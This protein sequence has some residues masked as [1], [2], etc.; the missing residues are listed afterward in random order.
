MKLFVNNKRSLAILIA[1]SF[2]ILT[3]GTA[4]FSIAK[5]AGW[6]TF[7]KDKPS[8]GTSSASSTIGSS[9]TVVT[10]VQREFDY[11]S[12]LVTVTLTP[13]ADYSLNQDASLFMQE[14]GKISQELLTI[15][16]NAVI[17]NTMSGD[18]PIF[19]EGYTAYLGYDPMSILISELRGNNFRIY[20]TYDLS[21]SYSITSDSVRNN[22]ANLLEFCSK[23]KPDGILLDG[24]YNVQNKD[25]PQ[26]YQKSGYSIPQQEWLYRMSAGNLSYI[27]SQLKKE[28]PSVEIG[29]YADSVY[30]NQSADVPEGSKTKSAFESYVGG[31]IDVVPLIKDK[32]FDFVTVKAGGSLTDGEIPFAAVAQWWA[33]LCKSSQTPCFIEFSNQKLLNASFAGWNFPDQL[34]RQT[35]SAKETY[36]YIGLVYSSYKSL[37]ENKQGST[38]VLVKYFDAEINVENIFRDLTMFE[39]N[40]LTFSTNE[41]AVRFYGRTDPYF[42]IFIN[43][44]P[45][46]RNAQG[47][48]YYLYNLNVGNNTIVLSHKGK[49]VTYNIKRIVQVIKDISPM[50]NQELDG[51]MTISVSAVA[52]RNSSVKATFNKQTI[53]LSPQPDVNGEQGSDYQTYLGS[54][55]LP[56]ATT[57]AQNLGSIVISASFNG[58]S[59]TKTGGTV[60]VRKLDL[61]P[62]ITGI[63][64]V[65]GSNARCFNGNTTFDMPLPDQYSSMPEYTMDYAVGQEIS[66]WNGSTYDTFIKGLSG[67]KYRIKSYSSATGKTTV[68][69]EVK[70]NPVSILGDNQIGSA[71]MENTGRY[72]T[73]VL[74]NNW[75]IPFNVQLNGIVYRQSSFSDYQVQSY[76]PDTVTLIFDY[77][78]KSSDFTIPE[79]PMFTSY[80]WEAATIGEVPVMK[81]HLKLKKMGRFLGFTTKYTKEG[82]LTFT[83]NNFPTTIESVSNSYGSN[84][85]KGA[86]IALE[87]GHIGGDVGATATLDGKIYYER[88]INI[89]LLNNIKAKLES[90]GATVLI[91]TTPNGTPESTSYIAARSQTAVDAGAHIYLSLHHNAST[92]TS[93]YG[94]ENYYHTPYSYPLAKYL[95]DNLKNY[96]APPNA[97][98]PNYARQ[99]GV[100][101]FFYK[102]ATINSGLPSILME[103]GFITNSDELRFILTE[104]GRNGYADTTVSAIVKYFG[105]MM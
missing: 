99:G 19:S 18:S 33:D 36:G 85:L 92:S 23:Y 42:E 87:Q 69:N 14:I 95:Y 63:I 104:E 27:T 10:P 46:A 9:D 84:N 89:A 72:T 8:L 11:S 5:D 77:T 94:F 75:C 4:F 79:N 90:L 25:T 39:P 2:V 73:L 1:I 62:S 28:M 91:I 52:Y 55:K 16:V 12:T 65:I 51:E 38:D 26:L 105:D 61:N 54:Y 22:A 81:L 56:K 45:A 70:I 3:A 44:K 102:S 21:R 98:K 43:G 29:I 57:A 71:V 13:N 41:S 97:A 48:F 37:M 86:V 7:G 67:K 35:I 101:A 93:A 34:L 59:E 88:D 76:N 40:K 68:F 83:F 50:G 24:Y 49:S 53:T 103:Y 20:T 78:V 82:K 96:T 80:T 17:L 30:R 100:P 66:A 74:D 32:T 60:T 64:E 47:D 15:G 58:L 6:L 31:L